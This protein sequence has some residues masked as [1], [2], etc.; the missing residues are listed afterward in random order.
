MDKA[1]TKKNPTSK[2]KERKQG[3]FSFRPRTTV[4]NSQSGFTLIEL[5]VVIIIIGMISTIILSA[6]DTARSKGRDGSRVQIMRQ[7]Q[8]AI[9]I[10]KTNNGSYPTGDY[11]GGDFASGLGPQIETYLSSI[12]SDPTNLTRQY[13]SVDTYLQFLGCGEPAQGSNNNYDYILAYQ[14]E[15]TLGDKFPNLYINSTEI[16]EFKCLFN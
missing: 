8:N 7:I 12:S 14:H 16:P 2:N 9:E 13:Y 10:K 15:G 3:L 6:L 5:L 4:S 1:H 11:S